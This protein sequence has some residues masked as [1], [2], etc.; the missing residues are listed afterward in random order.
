MAVAIDC[1]SKAISLG[2]Q[3][4]DVLTRRGEV[5]LFDARLDEA[6]AD[7][8]AALQHDPKIPNARALRAMVFHLRSDLETAWTEANH[9]LENGQNTAFDYAVRAHHERPMQS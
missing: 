2:D 8:D 9:E 3:P 1:Y 5:F 7:F 6:L 4:A